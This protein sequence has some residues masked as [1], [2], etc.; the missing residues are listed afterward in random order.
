MA[1]AAVFAVP[2]APA[3]AAELLTNGGFETGTFSGWTTTTLTA[4]LTPWTVATVVNR[5][6]FV[7]ASPQQGIFD[8]L[9]GFDGNGPGHFTL[10][11]TVTIP[12]GATVLSWKDRIQYAMNQGAAARL[13]EVKILDDTTNA[14]LATVYTFTTGPGDGT[15]CS[16]PPGHDTG[17]QTHSVDL[18]AFGGQTVKLVFD[19]TIP[20]NLTGPG[21]IEFDAISVL[22]LLSISPGTLAFGSRDVGDG[23]SATQESTLTNTTGGT[24]TLSGLTLAGA[25][26]T[27]FE[28]RSAQDG[29]CTSSTVLLAGE[30]CEVGVNFDPTTVGAKAATLTFDSNEPDVTVALTGTGTRRE[31]SSGPNAFAFGPRDIDDGS[32]ATDVS[33]LT[34]SGVGTVTLSGLTLS[35]D[36]GQF[37]RLSGQTGDC[38]AATVLAAGETCALRLRFDPTSTGAKS[39]TLTIASDAD[40]VT[41]ALTGT[42]TQTALTRSPASLDLG[43][44]DIDD[45]PTA[46]QASLVTNSGTEPVTLSTLTLSGDSEQFELLTGEPGDCAAATVLTAGQTCDVRL[47]FDPTATGAK[48]AAL[49]V[50]SNAADVAVTLSGSGTQIDTDGDGIGNSI[51]TDDDGDGVADLRD[52]FPLNAAESVDTDR[53]G[54]GNNA[55][56]DDDGDGVPDSADAFPLDASRKAAPAPPRP[57]VAQPWTLQTR[58]K[59]NVTRRT[60]GLLVSTGLAAVCPAGAPAC[61]GRLTLKVMRRS[62]ATG[63]VRPLFLTG[64]VKVTT[65]AAGTERRVAFRLNRPGSRLLRELGSFTATLRGVVAVGRNRPVVRTATMRISAPR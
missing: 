5:G 17:W 33:T 14:L 37:D 11:Q 19:E 36:A 8:A 34:N 60:T 26:P 46:G 43:T 52:A 4:P 56:A 44:R 61:S 20:A 39:A 55:D 40:D 27:Q 6:F 30:T 2:A 32:T 50:T 22:Q 57:G 12:A 35:G 23:P 63:V 21:Q 64:K 18:S 31:L 7:S 54:I 53:D 47:R 41:V 42:G 58:A 49:T 29:D 24:V 9:N 51:D 38:T 25:D 13:L 10:S 3:S 1:G 16:I 48:T 45:G 15:C 65:V 59:A 28:L 62:P